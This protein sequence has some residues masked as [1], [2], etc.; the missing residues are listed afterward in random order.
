[1]ATEAVKAVAS[2][3]RDDRHL[4]SL[5][6]QIEDGFTDEAGVTLAEAITTNKT[7]RR[8][9]L[10]DILFASN[11]IRTRAS[12]GA[13]AYEAFGTMLRVNTSLIYELPDVLFDADACDERDIEH[14][15]QMRIEQRLNKVG[16]GRLL[17]PSRASREEWVNALQELHAPNDDDLFE[18]G[19]LHSLLQLHP[20]VC[21]L[22]LNDTTNPDT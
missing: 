18:V 2:A 16:R 10:D 8:L 5:T 7:L 6:L 11:A 14:F 3:I 9:V 17:M 1:M 12:L 4:E 20:D 21:M 13:Q 19:C 22:E 15:N